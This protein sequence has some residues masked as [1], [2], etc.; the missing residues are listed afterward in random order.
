MREKVSKTDVA[1]FPSS[2]SF[3][4]HGKMQQPLRR[5]SRY[6]SR[7]TREIFVYLSLSVLATIDS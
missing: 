6:F 5:T 3:A 4:G 7:D 1:V 2:L